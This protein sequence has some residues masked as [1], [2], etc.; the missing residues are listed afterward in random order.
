VL[1]SRDAGLVG[2]YEIEV[3]PG[4]YTIEVESVFAGFE[5]GSS[6]GPFQV[7]VRIPGQ[8]EFWND[9]ESSF[10]DVSVKTP[11]RFDEF[12]D[13]GGLFWQMAPLA[14]AEVAEVQA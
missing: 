12:E 7:P 9:T 14:G 13:S 3:P 8:P 6:V 1:G 4:T 5:S 2:Y 10:D 11:P